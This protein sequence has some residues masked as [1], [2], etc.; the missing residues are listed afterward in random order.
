MPM[1]GAPPTR[2]SDP[3]TAPP[4]R[5]RSSSEIPVEKRISFEVSS[6]DNLFGLPMDSVAEPPLCIPAPLCIRNSFIL[7]QAPQLGHFPAQFADSYPHS[8]QQYTV[9]VF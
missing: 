5:T 1:P 7:F 4:P 6:S 8:A 3:Q 9:F 2:I